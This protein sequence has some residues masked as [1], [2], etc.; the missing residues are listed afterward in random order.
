[1]SAISRCLPCLFPKSPQPEQAP[2]QVSVQ[3]QKGKLSDIPSLDDHTVELTLPGSADVAMEE[4]P[5]P[6]KS[7]G[8]IRLSQPTLARTAPSSTL[9]DAID[10]IIKV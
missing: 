10:S 5:R 7:K 4:A 9:L 1:M 6:V 8:L 2:H 3:A